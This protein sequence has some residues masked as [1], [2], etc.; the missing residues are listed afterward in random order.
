MKSIFI[1]LLLTSTPPSAEPGHIE[2]GYI[3]GSLK[4]NPSP[5]PAALKAMDAKWEMDYKTLRRFLPKAGWVATPREYS[6]PTVYGFP[7]V[8]CGQG[9]QA[10]CSSG[11][12]KASRKS[13]SGFIQQTPT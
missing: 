3:M 1:A 11:F 8:N 2:P 5:M 10:V 12:H 13:F 9:W 4:A 7:E 6:H